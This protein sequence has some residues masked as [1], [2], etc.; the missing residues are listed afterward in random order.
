MN[1]EEPQRPN[2]RPGAHRGPKCTEGDVADGYG[3]PVVAGHIFAA[4]RKAGVPDRLGKD[5]DR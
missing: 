4:V 1:P 5:G 2:R 3:Q